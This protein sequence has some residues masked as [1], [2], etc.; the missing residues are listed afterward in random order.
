[1]L[2]R[3]LMLRSLRRLYEW[4]RNE[5]V[6]EELRGW[7]WDKP[8]LKPRGYLGLSVSEIA[9]KYCP[10]RRDI[11]LRR[12]LGVKPEA[13]EQL[14][15]GRAIHE[16]IAL[17][18]REASRLLVNNVEP[19]EIPGL[20]GGKWRTLS[21]GNTEVDREIREVYLSTLVMLA[22]E[23][24]YEALVHGFVNPLVVA[25]HKVDGSNLG[26]SSSLSVDTVAE[27]V[28]IDYKTGPPRD[29]HRLSIAG[30]ALALESELEI[31]FDYGILV[32]VSNSQPGFRVSYKPVYVSNSLRRLFIEERDN[33][34][35]MLLEDREP[36]RDPGCNP[37]ACPFAK[38]CAQ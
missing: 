9:G 15:R 5:P 35:D 31:P 3:R 10:T 22:G 16:A 6:D 30:Y 8:P 24:T 33:I 11:W 38:V 1:M 14:T 2:H 26:L 27:N 37:Q 20:A 25:E 12:K 23:A 32:Y 21:T 4:S 36:P 13:V 17:A 29:F 19:W 7:N 34:I 18:I 28:I